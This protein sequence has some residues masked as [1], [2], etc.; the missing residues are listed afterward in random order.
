MFVG[1]KNTQV[2]EGSCRAVCMKLPELVNLVTWF[3]FTKPCRSAE[4][5]DFFGEIL[6][7]KFGAS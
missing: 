2:M 1:Y 6:Y 3:P 7:R 4:I 5:L